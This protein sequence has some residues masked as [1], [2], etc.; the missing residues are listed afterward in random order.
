MN[1]ADSVFLPVTVKI[2]VK[3]GIFFVYR[4]FNCREQ[5]TLCDGDCLIVNNAFSRL[6]MSVIVL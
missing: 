1:G 6:P 2:Q 5:K 3:F 4:N